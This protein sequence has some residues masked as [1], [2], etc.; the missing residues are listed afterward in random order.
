LRHFAESIFHGWEEASKRRRSAVR[1]DGPVPPTFEG[2]REDGGELAG[3]GTAGGLPLHD[4]THRE[5]T[6]C[7]IMSRK[8]EIIQ[9]FVFLD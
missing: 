5:G 2:L 8:P 3:V 1:L 9:G 6:N 7:M 4:A